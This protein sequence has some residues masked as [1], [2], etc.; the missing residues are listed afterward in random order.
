[1][2]NKSVELIISH[3]DKIAAKLGVTAAQMWPWLVKQ[4]YVEAI[5]SLVILI[6]VS[7]VAYRF[8][9][10]TTVHWKPLGAGIYSIYREDH[11]PLY[12]LA[13]LVVGSILVGSII[14]FITNF[15]VIFNPEY[16]AL[17]SLLSLVKG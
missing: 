4:Q 16:G 6:I 15:P 3:L 13:W 8:L 9:R 11:Q 10:F 14:A 12:L 2:T 17:K 7:C 5:W 1:M